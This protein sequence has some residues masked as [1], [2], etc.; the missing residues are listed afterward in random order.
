MEDAAPTPLSLA[1]TVGGEANTLYEAAAHSHT[2]LYVVHAIVALVDKPVAVPVALA[3]VSVSLS[4]GESVVA[5]HAPVVAPPVIAGLHEITARC[6]EA[7]ANG[8]LLEAVS[9]P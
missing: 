9:R 8:L 4:T 5:A 7:D 1:I 6:V 3:L 2:G